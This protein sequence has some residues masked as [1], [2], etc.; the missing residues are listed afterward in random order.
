[1]ASP[2][3][4]DKALRLG[5]N[6]PLGP[7]ELGDAISAWTVW[8]ASEENSIS[9][10]GPVNGRLHPLLKLMVRAGYSSIYKF[11]EEVLSKW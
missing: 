4:I 10:I 5:Y 3:D 9:E 2:Q 6:L 11:W 7:L 8:A 1:M